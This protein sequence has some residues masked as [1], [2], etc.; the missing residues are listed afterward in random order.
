[1][2]KILLSILTIGVVGT[3]AYFGYSKAFFSDVETS[4]GNV[5]QAGAL[6]LKIDNTCYYNGQACTQV[7]GNTWTWG[8]KSDGELC[9]CTWGAKDL[10]A[11]DVF[12]NFHDL[13]PGDWEE[14]TIS[15]HVDNPAWVCAKANFTQDIDNTCTGPELKDE[16]GCTPTGKGELAENL[17]FVFWYDDGDN[18]LE[19]N[20]T[21][22]RQEKG[23]VTL[24]SSWPI[25][26]SQTGNGAIPAGKDVFI[27][28]AF[29]YGTMGLAPLPVGDHSP[30]GPIS[31]S[32]VTC[33]GKPVNNASQTDLVTGDIVFYAE[34]ARHN[35]NFVCSSREQKLVLEN[36][37]ENPVGPWFIINDDI[38][39]TLTWKGD[40][41]TFNY[42][43]TGHVTLPGTAYNLIYYADPWPGNFP[44]AFIG[45]GTS[46]AGGNIA[47]SGN[48]DL[49][50]DLPKSPDANIGLHGG[51]KIWL[52]K[53]ADYNSGALSTGPMTGWDPTNYLFEGNVY[54]NYDDTNN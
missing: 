24:A 36:E 20:E 37:T 47:F 2:K 28:K 41:P 42:G 6:D 46:D 38:K 8:G 35:D 9:S 14:D 26:D 1:M 44:G 49:G 3:V 5:L 21:I 50:K 17:Q 27:G 10:A 32:G 22:V 48:P 30:V 7:E 45:T 52:V 15:L 33:D 31:N 12:F 23:P 29:C 11:G 25:A 4:T 34:Q 18:V 39:G 19:T 53:A 43:F 54:I 51:A 16:P 13:K 40:G